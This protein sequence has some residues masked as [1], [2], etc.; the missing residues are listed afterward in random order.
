MCFSKHLDIL[1]S[2]DLIL[3]SS[4]RNIVVM[5]IERKLIL[6]SFTEVLFFLSFDTTKKVHCTIHFS[7]ILQNLKKLDGSNNRLYFPEINSED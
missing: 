5:F 4:L 6:I 1:T 2:F 3:V 7:V